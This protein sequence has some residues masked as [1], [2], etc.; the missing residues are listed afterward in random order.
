MS[1]ILREFYDLMWY[2][3]FFNVLDN[4]LR[5]EVLFFDEYRGVISWS[6]LN[7][8]YFCGKI[9]NKKCLIEKLMF[10]VIFV[11]GMV[12]CLVMVFLMYVCCFRCLWNVKSSKSLVI[13]FVEVELNFFLEDVIWII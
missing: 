2:F 7:N 8:F 3:F 12:G 1:L 4:D 6:F 5:G 9:L 13:V 10:V 11:G